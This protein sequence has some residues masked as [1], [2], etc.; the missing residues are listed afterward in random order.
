MKKLILLLSI[1]YLASCSSTSL[2][3]DSKA[4]RPIH[5]FAETIE[6]KQTGVLINSFSGNPGASPSILIRG[7]SSIN[8]STEPLIILDGMRYSGPLSMINPNDIESVEVLK[9]PSETSIYGIQGANG[10]IVIK[11]K[12]GGKK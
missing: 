7:I 3:S 6:G 11:T 12:K 2:I 10:V 1:M 9:N 8:A 5:S 4:E